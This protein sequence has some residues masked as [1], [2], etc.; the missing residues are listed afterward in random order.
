M[1]PMLVRSF[2]LYEGLARL[3]DSCYHYIGVPVLRMG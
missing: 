2:A 3:M 1:N